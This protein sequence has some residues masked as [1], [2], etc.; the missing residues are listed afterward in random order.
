MSIK[1]KNISYFI[2]VFRG[3]FWNILNFSNT[4]K[5]RK[6]IQKNRIIDDYEIEKYMINHSIELEGIR[7]IIRNFIGKK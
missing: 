5:F 2:A 4:M 7:M 3:Y 1:N 6:E